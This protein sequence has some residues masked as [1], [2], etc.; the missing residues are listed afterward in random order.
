LILVDCNIF[1]IDRFF[2]R[3]PRFNENK[4]FIDKI[5]QFDAYFSIFSLLELCGIAS[6][7]LSEYEIRLLTPEEFNYKYN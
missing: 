7:N 3:D 4:I 1:L 6:F 5:N 2:K